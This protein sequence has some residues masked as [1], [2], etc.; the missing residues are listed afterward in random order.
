[1]GPVVRGEITGGPRAWPENWVHAVSHFDFVGDPGRAC[2]E[3]EMTVVATPL[4]DLK[5][6]EPLDGLAMRHVN[7]SDPA[8]LIAQSLPEAGELR[9][10]WRVQLAFV[11]ARINLIPA[12]KGVPRRAQ[13][14]SEANPQRAD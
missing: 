11:G 8:T 13:R 12:M 3:A 7:C 5:P 6:V 2:V 4:A 10:A 14:R 1:M 9:Q